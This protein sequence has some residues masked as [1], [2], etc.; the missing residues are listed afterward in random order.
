VIIL[1]LLL[2]GIEISSLGSSCLSSYG[3][4][5]IKLKI[6]KTVL[7]NK[8]TSGEITVPDLLSNNKSDFKKF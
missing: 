1:F 3:L 4:W 7:N 2:S 8:R 5:D 6:A